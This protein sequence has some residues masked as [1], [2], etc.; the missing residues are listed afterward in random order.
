M[1]IAESPNE[2]FPSIREAAQAPINGP[3]TFSMAVKRNL[4]V[5][6]LNGTDKDI[7]TYL[8]GRYGA[9]SRC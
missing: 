2:D 1:N 4:P 6:K 9:T 3:A 5:T 7:L 8:V